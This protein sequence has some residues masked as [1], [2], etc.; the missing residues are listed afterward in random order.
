MTR[1][2]RTDV[3]HRSMEASAKGPPWVSSLGGRLAGVLTYMT[4]A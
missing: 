3:A 2:L 1:M 4:G